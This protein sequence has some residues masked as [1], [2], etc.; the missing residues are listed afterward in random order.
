MSSTAT[1]FLSVCL[2]N[3]NKS[4]WKT[5]EEA[6]SAV[7]TDRIFSFWILI[8]LFYSFIHS[9]ESKPFLPHQLL[10]SGETPTALF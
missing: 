7:I 6:F 8:V 5:C 1:T 10:H 9:E 3:Q 2:G 4:S